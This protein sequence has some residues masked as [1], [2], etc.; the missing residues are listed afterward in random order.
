MHKWL[1]FLK[2]VHPWVSVILLGLLFRIPYI[3]YE[4]IFSEPYII[5]PKICYSRKTFLVVTYLEMLSMLILHPV[6]ASLIF[7]LSIV[8]L[9][10]YLKSYFYSTLYYFLNPNFEPHLHYINFIIQDVLY[11]TLEFRLKIQI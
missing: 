9:K 3:Y 8:F 10:S 11:L 2:E 1:V 5:F 6:F 4:N 7:I